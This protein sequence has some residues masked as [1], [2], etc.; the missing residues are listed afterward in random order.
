MAKPTVIWE[1]YLC[2]IQTYE[3]VRPVAAFATEAAAQECAKTF[4]P[5]GE[6]QKLVLWP[7][8]SEWVAAG[9]PEAEDDID[10][11]KLAQT[12]TNNG[13]DMTVGGE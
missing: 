8:M 1:V 9:E 7:G 5:A 3:Y 12:E 13:Q 2:D 11:E 4:G 6:I 10:L